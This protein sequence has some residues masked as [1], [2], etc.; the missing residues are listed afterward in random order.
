MNFVV[1]S[2]IVLDCIALVSGHATTCTDSHGRQIELTPSMINDDY[3]DC[4]VDGVDEDLTSACSF[5]STTMFTCKNK[6]DRPISIYSSRVNDG[7]SFV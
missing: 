3:C 4:D 6:D 2:F 1:E 5:L 7:V